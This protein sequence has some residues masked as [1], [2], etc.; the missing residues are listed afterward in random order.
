MVR[1]RELLCWPIVLAHQGDDPTNRISDN[2]APAPFPHNGR[3]A[4]ILAA[5]MIS[6]LCSCYPDR[7]ATYVGKKDL[8]TVTVIEAPSKVFLSDASVALFPKGFRLKG[9]TLQGMGWRYSSLDVVSNVSLERLAQKSVKFPRDSAVAMTYFDQVVT[10]GRGFASFFHGLF[11]AAITPLSIY[12]MTNPKACFGCCPTVYTRNGGSWEFQAELFS[13]SISRLLESEDLD[14]LCQRTSPDSAFTL[15]VANE[16]LETHYI[17]LMQLVAVRHPSGTVAFPTVDGGYAAVGELHAPLSAVNSEGRD[18]LPKVQFWDDQAYRSDSLM[19]HEVR[20]GRS[21]DWIDV[22]VRPPGRTRSATMV[23]RLKNTLLST[24]LFYEVVLGSQGVKAID[25]T[26]RMNS[27]RAYAALFRSVYRQFS[28]VKILIRKDDSWSPLGG[29]PDAGPVG[30]K[31]IAARIPVNE[32]EDLVL[33]LEFFPD[34]MMIDYI[35]FDFTDDQNHVD[36]SVV[37]PCSVKDRT[38]EPRPDILP[39]IQGDDD[40]RLVTESRD[41][42]RFYYDLPP[43]A[44]SEMTLFVRSKGYYTEWIRGSWI[45]QPLGADRFDLFQINRTM[46]RLAELWLQERRNMESLFFRNR[47]PVSEE[48]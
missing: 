10:T 29:I 38:G 34:N 42:Y 47:I 26:Q 14:K 28:G 7:Q 13:Y 1:I 4:W 46:T 2:S 9:D 43:S 44:G 22:R 35:G 30:W 21:A 8:D 31:P 37:P 17:N 24:V 16:A 32:G 6:M 33:R 45:S 36:A 12:C 25:W 19:V 11:G 41:V 23:V 20:S 48:L 3:G 27:D 15:R 39:L 5:V 18:V 40:L